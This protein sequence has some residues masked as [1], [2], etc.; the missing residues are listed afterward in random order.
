MVQPPDGVAWGGGESLIALATGLWAVEAVVA[1]RLVAS[2]PPLLAGAGRMAFGLVVL[3]GYLTLTG[4]LGIVT[5]LGIAQWAW[6]L[7]TG[8]LLAGYVATWYA[9]LQRAPAA[10][11]AAVLTL[12]A[13]ITAGLQLL[14]NG[15]V[16]TAGPLAGYLLIVV[17]GGGLTAAMLRARQ[18][19][20]AAPSVLASS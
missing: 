11:V 20:P 19:A 1:R 10:V 8:A 15:N 16:P 6:V 17:A 9:A 5:Q 14:A 12:G 3:F 18:P 13:P 4:R 7:G 2:V